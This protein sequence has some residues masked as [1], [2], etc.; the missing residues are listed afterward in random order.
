MNGN[1]NVHYDEEAD[2]LEIRMGEA[3]PCYAEEVQPGIII[4]RDEQT[5]SVKSIGVVDFR[6]RSDEGLHLPVDISISAVA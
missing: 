2:F 6:E 4:R 1:M 3:T 5:G